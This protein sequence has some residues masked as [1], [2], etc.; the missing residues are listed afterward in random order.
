MN[1]LKL[2]D[3]L[4]PTLGRAASFSLSPFWGEIIPD[5]QCAH[6]AHE[7]GSG[8]FSL[9][10]R[11]R[12]GERARERGGFSASVRGEGWGEG[13]APNKSAQSQNRHD[14]F[15]VAQTVQSHFAYAPISYEN[16]DH[17]LAVCISAHHR[18]SSGTGMDRHF[19]RQI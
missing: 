9:S 8:L 14:S 7:Q 6:R 17:F 16:E 4:S 10:P 15:Y 5:R 13:A 19:R 1:A 18:N 2:V 12:S 3:G 11:R